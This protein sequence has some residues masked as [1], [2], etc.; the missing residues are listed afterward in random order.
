MALS[1]F[2]V[3]H[4]VD[5]NGQQLVIDLEL[6][7]PENLLTKANQFTDQSLWLV[8]PGEWMLRPAQQLIRLPRGEA[9]FSNNSASLKLSR[10]GPLAA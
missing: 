1:N 2:G 10:S 3:S 7:G 4:F 9:C 8:R 6:I 5:V